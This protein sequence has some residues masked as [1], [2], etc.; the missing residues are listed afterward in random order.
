[1]A[2][3]FRH[4]GDSLKKIEVL[5]ER[6]REARIR[7]AGGLTKYKQDFEGYVRDVLGQT[8]TPAQ[9]RVGDRYAAGER[10]IL[11]PSGNAVGKSF[12]AACIGLHNYDTK[13]PGLT[14]VTAPN[15]VQLKDI[16][17]KEMR[18]LAPGRKGWQPR[19]TELYGAP[20]HWVKGYTAKDATGF[21][22]RHDAFVLVIFDE[23]EGVDMPFWEA[24]E[25]MADQWI[26]FYNP[27]NTT[28]AA[29]T[30]ERSGTWTIERLSAL[31]HPNIEAGLAGLDPPYPRAVKLAD[32]QNRLKSWATKITG[33]E[34][35]HP[36]DIFLGDERWRLGPVAQARIAGIRPTNASNSVF[37]ERLWTKMQ[38]V[39]VDK[40]PDHWPLQI[41]AD[42]ALFGD[43]FVSFCV[44][45]GKCILSLE[46]HNGWGPT[47]IVE[48]LQRL[49][50]EYANP[51][52]D[53]KNIPI[54]IDDTGGYGSG[55]VE[56]ND[57]Y[58]FIGVHGSWKSDREDEYPDI[59]SQLWFDLADLVAADMV[60]ISRVDKTM[61]A[62]LYEDLITPGYSFDKKGRRQMQNHETT[63]R[64]MG[65]SPDLAD[66]VSL[67]FAPKPSYLESCSVLA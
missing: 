23:A 21:Q 12:I 2:K 47:Q 16:V 53:V 19:A 27:T 33:E 43:D 34:P 30:A 64:R 41:G 62:E 63:K 58:R 8:L 60:D 26:C 36:D 45:R 28:S 18:G 38:K 7:V 51:H 22:G 25:T 29:A 9:K 11:V 46:K 3:S 24:A 14:L 32:V 35:E 4:L 44:R 40:I 48:R 10:R 67:A 5:Y 1:M 61:Q 50:N 57:G 55:V 66:A 49:A 65:R 37:S 52:E 42:M 39:R 54:L 13:D 56:Y 17:F 6:L 15:A 59:R 20:N 31:E